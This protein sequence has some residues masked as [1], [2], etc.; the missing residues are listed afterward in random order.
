ME[1]LMPSYSLSNFEICHNCCMP[2]HYQSL[3]IHILQDRNTG[4]LPR[5]DASHVPTLEISAHGTKCR[6]QG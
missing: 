6:Q 5:P 1:D 4:I 2:F 3:H